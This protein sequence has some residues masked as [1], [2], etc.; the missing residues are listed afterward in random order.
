MPSKVYIVEKL[1]WRRLSYVG[2]SQ[3][4]LSLDFA[5]DDSGSR[6][7]NRPLEKRRGVCYAARR[8]KTV[9]YSKSL[10][11]VPQLR[12][13]LTMTVLRFFC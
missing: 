12:D 11:A 10:C 13:L 4:P 9:S 3:P 8:E 1:C 6:L 7:I 5:R 2:A